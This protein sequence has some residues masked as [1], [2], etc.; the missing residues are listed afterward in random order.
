MED[1]LYWQHENVESKE[2]NLKTDPCE[3]WYRVWGTGPIHAIF[4]H[5]GPGTSYLPVCNSL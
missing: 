2:Y 1:G 4:L 3:T 5:G